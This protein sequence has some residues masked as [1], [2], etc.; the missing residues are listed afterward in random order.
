MVRCQAENAK[1]VRFSSV[2]ITN[3]AIIFSQGPLK[4]SVAGVGRMFEEENKPIKPTLQ[5]YEAQ[6][7]V[8]LV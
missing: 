1:L 7:V 3:T 4:F 6:N 2:A 8:K 5:S